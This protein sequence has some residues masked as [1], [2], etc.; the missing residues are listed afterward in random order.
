MYIGNEKKKH[1]DDLFFIFYVQTVLIIIENKYGLKDAIF[2]KLLKSNL[3]Y[4][5]CILWM[6]NSNF[7]KFNQKN[8]Y[9]YVI[10]IW[11]KGFHFF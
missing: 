11:F 10:R 5:I 4:L 2:F 6:M 1:L 9:F 7:K 8:V 3:N